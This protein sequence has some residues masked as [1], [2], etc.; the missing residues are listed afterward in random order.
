MLMLEREC[1][2]G[3]LVSEWAHL[4]QGS[5]WGTRHSRM[6]VGIREMKLAWWERATRLGPG[7]LLCEETGSHKG[8]G[9]GF[10]SVDSSTGSR[11]LSSAGARGLGFRRRK[12]RKL[13]L[14]LPQT[15]CSASALT[16]QI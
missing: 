15:G 3:A 8:F 1:G 2:M 7:G 10:L 12:K 16:W 5:V 11:R 9:V 14:L 13:T 6:G 4:V